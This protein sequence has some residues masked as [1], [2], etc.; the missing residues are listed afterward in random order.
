MSI[1]KYTDEEI[2]DMEVFTRDEAKEYVEDKTK[3]GGG[4]W[5]DCIKPL[6]NFRPMLKNLKRQRYSHEV[7]PKPEVDQL[8]LKF[9]K[10]LLDDENY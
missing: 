6:L 5:K 4:L 8:I 2:I 7:V 10:G 9:K 3:A 1:E